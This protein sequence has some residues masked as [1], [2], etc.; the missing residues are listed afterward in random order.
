[1][2]MLVK[3]TN[4]CH[5]AATQWQSPKKEGKKATSNSCYLVGAN[6]G[7]DTGSVRKAI[8]GCLPS[9]RKCCWSKCLLLPILSLVALEIGRKKHREA[10]SKH[11]DMC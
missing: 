9:Q 2:N 7:T 10:T 8:S 11:K 6:E 3:D 5:S 4:R 1:M